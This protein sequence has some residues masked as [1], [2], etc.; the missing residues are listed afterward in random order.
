MLQYIA[1]LGRELNH[2]IALSLRLNPFD[3]EAS[4]F[5]AAIHLCKG[6]PFYGY[7]V[8]WRYFLKISFIDPSLNHRLGAI[9]ES[10]HVMR[11]KFQPYEAHIRYQL[12]FM[13]DYNLFGCDYIDIDA[14]MFRPPLPREWSSLSFWISLTS[15]SIHVPCILLSRR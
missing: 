10:G 4:Q 14:A 3:P 13:L 6:V 1:R 12:Q 5:I 11:T 9:L 7:H 15:R 2:S 8:G